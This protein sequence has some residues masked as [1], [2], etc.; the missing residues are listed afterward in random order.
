MHRAALN[1]GLPGVRTVVAA[2]ERAILPFDR[3]LSR[4]SDDTLLATRFYLRSF[5]F[6][7]AFAFAYIV[8]EQGPSWG[9][10][11]GGVYFTG[12]VMKFF[13]NRG[14]R[15]KRR[16]DQAPGSEYRY[17]FR[18]L[19]DL[20]DDPY[21]RKRYV[22]ILMHAPARRY[23]SDLYRTTLH[24]VEAVQ[25]FDF[26]YGS[27][28]EYSLRPRTYLGNWPQPV[29]YT[30]FDSPRDLSPMSDKRNVLANSQLNDDVP[31]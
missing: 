8:N 31:F 13:R 29:L 20:D 23:H 27:A 17:C 14:F 2:G 18:W 4:F 7:S 19:A 5:N 21:T 26:N 16:T 1:A 9:A 25:D 28:I 11:P 12:E 15:G 24:Q 3:Q 30:R 10:D 6:N 22:T